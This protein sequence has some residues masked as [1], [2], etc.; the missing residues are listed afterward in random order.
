MRKVYLTREKSFVA[1]LGMLRVLIEDS[2]YGDVKIDGT[3]CRVAAYVGN[4]ETVSFDIGNEATKIYVI[5][6]KLSKGYCSDYYPVPEGDTDIEISGKCKYNPALGNPFRFNGV[7]DETVLKSR[8]KAGLK[9]IIPI[10][11][12]VVIGIAIGFISNYERPK[13]FTSDDFEISLTTAFRESIEDGTYYLGSKDCSVAVYEFDFGEYAYIKDKSDTEFLEVLKESDF[14]AKDAKIANVEGMAVV[15]DEAE[16]NA[17]D[18]RS[19]F[20]LFIKDGE[21]YYLFEFGCE[22][23]EYEKHRADFIEWAKSVK[24]K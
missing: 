8:K 13:T 12:A 10:A 7:T 3:S 22:V 23:D 11:I 16:S 2:E 9:A 19:Y 17:G 24:L 21:A 1:S 20:T 18:I 14:F 4:G 5:A 15:E 6:D